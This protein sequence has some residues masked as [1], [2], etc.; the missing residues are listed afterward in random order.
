M[1]WFKAKYRCI[2]ENG[3]LTESLSSA[4]NFPRNI[5]TNAWVGAN[6][7]AKYVSIFPPMFGL[8]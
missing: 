6:D 5:D 8:G 4:S 1:T 7:L 2:A 3:K